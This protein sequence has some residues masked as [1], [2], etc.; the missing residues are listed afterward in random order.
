MPIASATALSVAAA[1]AMAAE[2]TR[3]SAA[4]TAGAL[5]QGTGDG[6]RGGTVTED[7]PASQAGGTPAVAP[8][9][10]V[11]SR[12]LSGSDCGCR[13]SVKREH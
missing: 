7:R 6:G 4:P 13:T 2:Y 9:L 3:S 8:S 11:G 12:A 5:L 1:L 10:A